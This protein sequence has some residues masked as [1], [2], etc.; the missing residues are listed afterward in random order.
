MGKIQPRRKVANRGSR[1]KKRKSRVTSRMHPDLRHLIELSWCD[2]RKLFLAAIPDFG[3]VSW[4]SSY[5][6]ALA[7]LAKVSSLTLDLFFIYQNAIPKPIHRPQ[8]IRKLKA[9]K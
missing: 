4:G 7:M 6:E 8:W 3:V 5:E 1:S 2:Q 9:P